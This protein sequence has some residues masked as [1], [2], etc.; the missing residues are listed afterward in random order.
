MGAKPREPLN[1]TRPRVYFRRPF[2]PPVVAVVVVVFLTLMGGLAVWNG[3][4][5]LFVLVAALL[6]PELAR[7]VTP[8]I[9]LALLWPLW[10]GVRLVYRHLRWQIRTPTDGEPPGRDWT[11]HCARCHRRLAAAVDPCPRCEQGAVTSPS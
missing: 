11:C 8:V 7:Y 10:L 6:S 5:W 9:Q 4:V 2:M 1:L 3:F